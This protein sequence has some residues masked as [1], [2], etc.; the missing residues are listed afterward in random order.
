MNSNDKTTLSAEI[1]I[2]APIEKV[3]ALWTTPEDI[4]QWNNPNAD[5]HTPRVENDLRPGGKFYT[6]MTGPDG[7]DSSGTGCFLEVIEGEKV[8]WTNALG[9][10]WRPNE[11]TRVA[12]GDGVVVI[13]RAT[14]GALQGFAAG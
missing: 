2:N 5:W 9:E 10:G 14:R 4:M 3:W 7:F 12:A 6:R 11:D 1:E 13:G 8:V